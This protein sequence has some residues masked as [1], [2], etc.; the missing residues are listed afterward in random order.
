[1]LEWL[2]ITEDLPVWY[3]SNPF[4]QNKQVCGS[5]VLSYRAVLCYRDTSHVGMTPQKKNS[6]HT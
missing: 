3:F 2:R 1:M 6:G 5:D 4:Q